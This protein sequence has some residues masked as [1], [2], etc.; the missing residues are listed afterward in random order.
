MKKGIYLLLISI[1]FT[2]CIKEGKDITNRD[3]KIYKYHE[4]PVEV[5]NILIN[6]IEDISNSENK[7]SYTTN[8]NIMFRYFRKRVYKNWLKEVNNNDEY[9]EVSTKVYRIKGN[10]GTPF[11][12]HKDKIFYADYNIDTTN[13]KDIEYYSV[14]LP[15]ND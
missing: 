7:M 4:L 12:L 10:K 15:L 11:I 9:F 8:K 2:S 14:T 5:Q 6:N 13:Y 1:L 3:F